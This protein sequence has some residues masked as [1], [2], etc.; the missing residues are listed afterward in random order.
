MSSTPVPPCDERKQKLSDDLIYFI[1]S[2][3]ASRGDL[4]T[5]RQTC[6]RNHVLLETAHFRA[7][8]RNIMQAERN[9]FN[10]DLHAFL[11]YGV[12]FIR[13]DVSY[14]DFCEGCE[15]CHLKTELYARP[16]CK[17]GTWSALH[18]ASSCGFSR[19]AGE[20][21]RTAK[22]VDRRYL[23]AKNHNG[24]TALSLAAEKGHIEI[25]R[26][27]INAGAF[28]YATGYTRYNLDILFSRIPGTSN[29][30][31]PWVPGGP[32][33]AFNPLCYAMAFR[34]EDAAILLAHHTFKNMGHMLYKDVCWPLLVAA[35]M[36][37]PN[38]MRIL[39]AQLNG[40]ETAGDDQSSRR[41]ILEDI[42][43]NAT[44][45]EH[46]YEVIDILLEELANLHTRDKLYCD[47]VEYA[48][49]KRCYGNARHIIQHFLQ[50]EDIKRVGPLV[51]SM[52][53][54]MAR[55][56]MGLPMTKELTEEL[57]NRGCFL[58]LHQ[59]LCKSFALCFVYTQERGCLG[60]KFLANFLAS[61]VGILRGGGKYLHW[62][63][64]QR[65]V[66][67]RALKYVLLEAPDNIDINAIDAK[68][69]TPLDIAIRHG[70]REAIDIL[71][72]HGAAPGK[73]SDG[74]WILNP[75]MNEDPIIPL[76]VEY[77]GRF[78]EPLL[79]FQL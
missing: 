6:R 52:L 4:G 27:L 64:S 79:L 8:V 65:D 62:L 10:S 73:G 67:I 18:W 14:R 55:D 47:V 37:M 49:S 40:I 71:R 70:H 21:I 45:I 25:I 11:N 66:H 68:E 48:M 1:A 34:Q 12:E 36:K 13:H 5:L 57:Y 59:A 38:I 78:N 56:D 9:K 75:P 22:Q 33:L 69:F 29:Q 77:N 53:G 46:N 19:I 20:I 60:K 24:L 2:N 74:I 44:R 39:F 16:C 43:N 30:G 50:M 17:K 26:Q 35:I 23:D 15:F 61:Q 63:L 54:C 32:W 72:E 42:L 51:A 58:Y 7:D 28:L 31:L 3:F 41:K 76:R